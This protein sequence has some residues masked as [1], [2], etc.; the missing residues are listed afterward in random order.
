MHSKWDFSVHSF[1]HMDLFSSVHYS[2]KQRY[3]SK[4]ERYFCWYSCV[5]LSVI[6]GLKFTGY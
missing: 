6:I 4:H 1:C 5:L 3:D 2:S